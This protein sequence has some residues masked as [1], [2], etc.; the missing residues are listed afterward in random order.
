LQLILRDLA[1]LDEQF[2]DSTQPKPLVITPR[3]LIITPRPQ[4][5]TGARE[6]LVDDPFLPWVPRRECSNRL[7]IGSM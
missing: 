7:K 2:A 6:T 4:V 5:E 1:G 3:C